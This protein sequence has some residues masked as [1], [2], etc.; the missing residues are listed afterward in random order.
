M[1]PRLKTTARKAPTQDRSKAMVDALL[2]AT[3][4]LLLR[5]GYDL[6]S[7]NRVAAEAGVSIGSLYQYFPSKEALLHGV[8][9]RWADIVMGRVMTLRE[10][11]VPADLSQGIRGLVK[12]TLAF[13]RENPRLHRVLLE[14]VPKVGAL[15]GLEQ[16][17]RRFEELLAAW[18]EAHVDELEVDDPTLAAHFVLRTLVALSDHALLYRPELL[19]SE[20]FARHLERILLAYLAPSK[21]TK[22]QRSA[23]RQS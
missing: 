3:T 5:D 8:M 7:T 15:D 22:R 6:L 17:N 2:D 21:F 23:Q 10:S 19:D 11:L 1:P 16:L 12:D 9:L 4:R 14:Q 13:N 18:L 20:R